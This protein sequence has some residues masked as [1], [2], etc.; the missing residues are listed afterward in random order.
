MLA[1]GLGSGFS[2]GFFFTGYSSYI[3]FF[4]NDIYKKRGG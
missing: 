3:G 1:L 4:L 2:F